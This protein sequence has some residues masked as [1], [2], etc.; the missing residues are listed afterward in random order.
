MTTPNKDRRP[1]VNRSNYLRYAEDLERGFHREATTFRHP[2]IMSGA[3]RRLGNVYSE[4]GDA[5]RARQW[6]ERAIDLIRGQ[7][8]D[9]SIAVAFMLWRMGDRERL[10]HECQAIIGDREARLP[11]LRAAM[12]SAGLMERDEV[13]RRLAMAIEDLASA[14]LYVGAF[15]AAG[16]APEESEP[17]GIE[18]PYLRAVRQLAQPLASQDRESFE[19][20]L[21]G[22]RSLTAPWPTFESNAVIDCYRLALTLGRESFGSIPDDLEGELLTAG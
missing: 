21:R 10:E 20:A 22:L 12:E 6:Y 16:S 18:T 9:P 13:C 7:R 17:L 2:S 19:A 14:H 11:D 3:A 8:S 5:D 1:A 15:N 4:F